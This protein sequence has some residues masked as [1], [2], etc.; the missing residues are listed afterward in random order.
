MD[1]AGLL[2]D[3]TAAREVVADTL[4]EAFGTV[5]DAAKARLVA[6]A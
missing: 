2:G 3:G 1:G 6:Q 4:E 5:L